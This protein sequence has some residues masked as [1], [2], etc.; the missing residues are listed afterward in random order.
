LT[1]QRRI[2][3]VTLYRT[4]FESHMAHQPVSTTRLFVLHGGREIGPLQFREVMD[5]LRTGVLA[6]DDLCRLEG[7]EDRAPLRLVLPKIGPP[8]PTRRALPSMSRLESTNLPPPERA[9]PSA[10]QPSGTG[11]RG[12]TLQDAMPIALGKES[13]DSLHRKVVIKTAHSSEPPLT[14]PQKTEAAPAAKPSSIA[15][16][17]IKAAP[18]AEPHLAASGKTETTSSPELSS[19]APRKNKLK[20]WGLGIA[21]GLLGAAV[22]LVAL[23][24]TV[25]FS[26]PPRQANVHPPPTSTAPPSEGSPPP[27]ATPDPQVYARLKLQAAQQA[28][29]QHD[30]PTARMLIDEADAAAPDQPAILNLRG[31]ILAELKEYDLAEAAFRK[32]IGID[33]NFYWAKKNLADMLWKKD[34]EKSQAPSPVVTPQISP[35]ESPTIVERMRGERFPQ[36]RLGTMT[37]WEVENWT[38]AELRYA[39]NEMYAR[40][41]AD[42]LDKEIKRQFTAFE[43][44]HPVSGQTYEQTENLFSTTELYNLK[45]LGHYRDARKAGTSPKSAPTGSGSPSSGS[46]QQQSA[47]KPK[48]IYRPHPPYPSAVDKM[49]VTGSGRFKITFDERG[50]AKSVEI[51][52]STKNHALDSNTIKTLKQWRIAPG[53]PCY[54]IVPI[55]YRQKQQPRSKP[56]AAPT[57]RSD[58]SSNYPYYPNYY[59]TNPVPPGPP[60]PR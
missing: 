15:P 20:M 48:F 44:Y 16:Q 35:A 58:E 2:A 41:G 52:Q 32:A 18:S 42:L 8:L 40:H 36:T 9:V 38:T 30:L 27:P 22:A 49:H 55:D 45:L 57:S 28:F 59:N 29:Q 34:A 7:A 53:S 17:R 3:D 56:K 1:L 4:S 31:Q 47:R 50:N 21:A 24:L 14:A 46:T 60:S 51:V 26:Q 10:E 11:F 19:A 23:L 25:I 5:Q 33:P 12:I 37:S 13:I 43:W 54:V 39:I 6:L